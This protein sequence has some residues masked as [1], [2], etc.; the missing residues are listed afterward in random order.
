VD[1]FPPLA[2]LFDLCNHLRHR[3]TLDVCDFLEGAPECIFDRD[4]VL[5]PIDGDGAL[6]DRRLHVP[7][8][9]ID[10]GVAN[11]LA[12]YGVDRSS[13]GMD[14]HSQNF[15]DRRARAAKTSFDYI[16]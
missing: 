6:G 16:F 10:M 9:T 4:P 12:L 8:S 3:R 5:A 11:H 15:N 13:A 14:L 2:R 1:K 7:L